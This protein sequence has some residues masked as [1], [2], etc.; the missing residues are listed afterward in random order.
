MVHTMRLRI[1]RMPP[2]AFPPTAAGL[3]PVGLVFLLVSALPGASNSVQLES[4]SAAQAHVVKG[5]H[6]LEVKDLQAAKAQFELAV[7]ANPKSVEARLG[8]GIA[9]FQ[10]GNTIA[11]IR[12]FRSVLDLDP[13]SFQG[14]YHLALAYL[15]DQ[16]LAE[17]CEELRRALAINPHDADAAYNLGVVLVELGEPEQ[18]LNYLRQASSN[19]PKRPDLTFNLIRGELAHSQFEQARREADAGAE[20]FGGDPAW[21]AAVGQLFL[22]HAQLNEAIRHLQKAFQLSPQ[23]DEIRRQLATAYLRATQPTSALLLL[24]NAAA[25]E[26]H[27]LA[28]SAYFYLHR[29]AEAD[30]ESARALEKEPG[31]PRYLLQRARIDQRMG[32]HLESLDLLQHASRAEPQWPEPY[33]S[34]GVAYYLLRR[35]RDAR[36]SLDRALSLEPDSVRALFLY[37]ACLANEGRNREGEDFLLQAIRNEPE[38]ARFYYH[39]GAIRLR[40]NRSAEAQQA[41]EKAIRLRPDYAPPHYQL[42]KL[43]VR[44]NQLQ[45]ASEELEKAVHYQPDLAQ[46]FYHLGRVYARLG[47]KE[48]SQQALSTFQKFKKQEVS[49]E[50]EFVEGVQTELQLM[51]R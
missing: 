17:G 14:H 2:F 12:C 21:C 27:Y 45:S 42:G 41:F 8:L 49:E 28:A 16:K 29:L 51:E 32:R 48:K 5:Q 44:S 4:G 1:K 47:D 31:D 30:R 7:K 20:A 35:Y 26:D 11:A 43:F 39:L 34:S 3:L 50:N 18:G 10:D 13:N 37:S 9:E 40:D 46:A 19:G 36:Q 6:A 24:E 38:N 15:R 25:A 22:E 33:Y 23:S